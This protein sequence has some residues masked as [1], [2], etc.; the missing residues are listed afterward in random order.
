MGTTKQVMSEELAVKEIHEY[1]SNFV[2]GEINVNENY[3]KT[4]D[5]VMQGR[6]VFESDLTPVY[7][8]ISPLYPDSLENKITE[9]KFKTRIKPTATATLAK[10]VDLKLDTV[11][12]SLILITHLAGLASMSELDNLSKKDYSFIQEFSPVFM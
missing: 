7:K 5:A 6:L 12:Y 2:D 9:L 8:L 3:P 4:L 11:R 1:L 10:G